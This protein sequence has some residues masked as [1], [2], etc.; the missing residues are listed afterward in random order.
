MQDIPSGQ[1]LCS[2]GYYE[3]GK[4]QLTGNIFHT[5]HTLLPYFKPKLIYD[6]YLNDNHKLTNLL[7]ANKIY[8]NKSSIWKKGQTLSC[9][10]TRRIPLAFPVKKQQAHLDCNTANVPLQMKNLLDLIRS[11]SKVEILEFQLWH[12]FTS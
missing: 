6:M 2:C 3:T 4:M 12:C 1:S 10:L 9:T 11:K 7:C 8:Q 5:N